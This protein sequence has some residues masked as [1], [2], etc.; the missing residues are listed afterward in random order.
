MFPVPAFLRPLLLAVATGVLASASLHAELTPEQKKE[1]FRKSRAAAS[2]SPSP[3][4]GSSKL[5]HSS[6]SGKPSSP[7]TKKHT[8]SPVKHSVAVAKK[9]S[10]AEPP[11]PPPRPQP[12]T[13]CRNLNRRLLIPFLLLFHSPMEQTP[14]LRSPLKNRERRPTR[15]LHRCPNRLL[16]FPPGDGDGSSDHA[17][18]I[19][20]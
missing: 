5:K 18:P 19:P 14:R 10:A 12:G 13:R 9:T 2:P 17:A 7:S 20:T 16:R 8:A 11:I 6:V 1:L 4:H 15:A 3:K